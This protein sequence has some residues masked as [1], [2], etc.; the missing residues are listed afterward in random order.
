MLFDIFE[1]ILKFIH[2][3]KILNTAIFQSVNFT[4]EKCAVSPFSMPKK[5]NLRLISFTNVKG[6]NSKPRNFSYHTSIWLRLLS[7]MHTV[8]EE[9][10]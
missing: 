4:V 3:R 8:E 6:W 7:T 1:S 2:R 10:D 9:F 5:S